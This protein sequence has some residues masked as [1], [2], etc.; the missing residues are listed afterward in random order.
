M[1]PTMRNTGRLAVL[2]LAVLTVTGCGGTKTV[3]VTKAP[4]AC[5]Q[6]L[7]Q[8]DS[9]FTAVGDELTTVK[10][11]VDDVFAGHPAEGKALLD[12]VPTP[13]DPSVYKALEARCR[14][15]R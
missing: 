3:T 10:R 7:D 6:A 13:P 4:P 2:T 8:A 15:A 9:A 1:V 5:V 14:A 12:S 11:A